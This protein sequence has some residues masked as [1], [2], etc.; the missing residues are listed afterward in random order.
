MENWQSRND[1]RDRNGNEDGN[2]RMEAPEDE[3]RH[4]YVRQHFRNL[5][6][7]TLYLQNK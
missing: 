4:V 2:E 6:L 1:Q 3:W 7:V 5:V